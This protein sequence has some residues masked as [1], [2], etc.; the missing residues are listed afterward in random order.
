MIGWTVLEH[1]TE[2]RE[3]FEE[4]ASRDGYFSFAAILR[5]VSTSH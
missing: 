3:E 5:L 1:M 2:I 4:S